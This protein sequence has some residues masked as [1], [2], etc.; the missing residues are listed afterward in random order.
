MTFGRP[1]MTS[2]APEVPKPL[3]ID[4]RYLAVD[5]EGRQPDG[6]P[7]QLAL[8]VSSTS[9]YDILDEILAK[10]Y[11]RRRDQQ[12]VLAPDS[13]LQQTLATILALNARLDSFL[14]SVPEYLQTTS[15]MSPF[16]L[17]TAGHIRLQQQILH[18]RYVTH[19]SLNSLTLSYPC[20][21]L[22]TRILL[23]RPLLLTG[24]KHN[25]PLN[26]NHH[27][28]MDLPH[29]DSDIIGSACNLCVNTAH[30]LIM[31]LHENMETPYR[32]SAWHTVY[33]KCT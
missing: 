33:C 15:A 6:C 32:L 27:R 4:D 23:L 8:F 25:S 19:T 11:Q 30:L 3:I 26:F 24:A 14:D 22:Y 12:P 28:T 29:L 5:C 21:F 13:S 1:M 20:R 18:C 10:L 9:L 16:N 7:S 17:E 2:G 31:K